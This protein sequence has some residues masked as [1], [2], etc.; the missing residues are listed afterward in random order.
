M[1]TVTGNRSGMHKGVGYMCGE[2]SLAF[3][4]SRQREQRVECEL[5]GLPQQQQREQQLCQPPGLC[6]HEAL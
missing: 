3:C 2:R 6:Q 4:E 1:L 5:H